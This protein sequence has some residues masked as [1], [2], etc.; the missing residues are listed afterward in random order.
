MRSW[1]LSEA[2]SLVLSPGR[3]VPQK[4]HVTA[5]N[6]IQHVQ[7]AALVIIGNGPLQTDLLAHASV[8][9]ISDRVRVVPW[10]IDVR[11]I[12]A[13]ADALLLPSRWEGHGLVAVEAMMASLPVVAASSPGLREWLVHEDNALLAPVADDQQLASCLRPRS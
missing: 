2:L 11:S 5:I 3:L 7:D 1:G 9:N 10:R 6:A 12:M 4:D 8:L 13:A